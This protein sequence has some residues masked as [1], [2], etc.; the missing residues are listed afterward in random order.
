MEPVCGWYKRTNF[1][2][3]DG[4]LIISRNSAVSGFARL[5]VRD[6]INN[7]SRRTWSNTSAT[8]KRPAYHGPCTRTEKFTRADVKKIN[9]F[10]VFLDV[11]TVSD[12]ATACGKFIS[13]DLLYDNPSFET[14]RE[15]KG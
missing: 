10:K 3:H 15:L 9:Y 6:A 1:G 2:K 7:R 5:Y 11:Q 4:N 8:R 12:I 14:N 13:T